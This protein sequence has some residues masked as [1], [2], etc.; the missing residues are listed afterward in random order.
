MSVMEMLRGGTSSTTTG[1]GG[2]R[3]ALQRAVLAGAGAAAASA[4]A[5]VLPALLVWVAASQSTV[6]W[7]TALGVGASLWLLGTGAHLT[8]G[9]AHVT[10]V[11]LAFLAAAVVGATWAAVRAAR[12]AAQDRTPVHL[13]DLVH[14]PLALVLASWTGGYAACA[15]IWSVVALAAGPSPAV[16]SLVVPVLVVPAVSAGAALGWLAGGRP[17]LLGSRVRRPG[18]LPDAARRALRPGLEGATA[19]LAAG[20]VACVVMVVFR[21]DRVSHLQ[22]ELAPGIIGGAVLTLAQVLALPNL[23]LWAVSFAA[24]TGFSAVQ[25]ASASWTGSRTS[26]LPMVPVFGALPDPGAFPGFPSARRAGAVGRGRTHRLAVAA[27]GRTVVDDADQ[28]DGDGHRGR[29]GCELPRAARCH[30]GVVARGGAA[31]GHRGS[32]R[33]DDPGPARGVRRGCRTRAGLGPLEAAAL[34]TR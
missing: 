20:V 28:A 5:C 30:R 24:G 6:D 31:V 7:T 9:A 25:G 27:R 15:A 21:F 13:A 16:P 19:L 1:A 29:R 11:P 18:W 4:C 32:G 26:L 23:A 17:E 34:T 3:Q 10:M 8:I 22:S 14:R 12:A 33:C 2:D